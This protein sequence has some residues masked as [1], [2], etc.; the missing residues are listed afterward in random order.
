M[1]ERKGEGV[2]FAWFKGV[3]W[4]QSGYGK[5]TGGFG[6]CGFYFGFVFWMRAS[7]WGDLEGTAD[8]LRE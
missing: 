7:F 5:D 2:S 8:S 4:A 6:G 3:P 1:C